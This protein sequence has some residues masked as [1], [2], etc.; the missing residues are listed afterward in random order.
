MLVCFNFFLKK[1][2]FD[3]AMT[4]FGV[5]NGIRWSNGQVDNGAVKYELEAPSL[6]R[7]FVAKSTQVI[8]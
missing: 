3:R 4:I 1:G 7:C 8:F 2:N 5:C 6:Q